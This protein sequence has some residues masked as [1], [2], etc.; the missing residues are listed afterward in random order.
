MTILFDNLAISAT[1]EQT[2]EIHYP[3][4]GA[5]ATTY[6]IACSR[7]GTYAIDVEMGT[8]GFLEVASGSLTAGECDAIV[9]DLP[10]VRTRVRVTP[11]DTTAGTL[12]GI[13]TDQGTRG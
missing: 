6:L 12:H 2:S 5:V 8:Q 13:A 3:R 1:T 9:V 11:A 4:P 10:K 7:G